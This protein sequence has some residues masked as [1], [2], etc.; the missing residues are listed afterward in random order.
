MLAIKTVLQSC[1]TVYETVFAEI[2]AKNIKQ[3]LYVNQKDI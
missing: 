3:S 2:F 1:Y